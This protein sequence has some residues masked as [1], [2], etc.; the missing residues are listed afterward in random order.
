[1]LHP[2]P[3]RAT[4][5]RSHPPLPHPPRPL[6]RLGAGARAGS[7]STTVSWSRSST[8]SCSTSCA[9]P[10]SSATW[11]TVTNQAPQSH[12]YK[13]ISTLLTPVRSL[14][15]S[16]S[17]SLIVPYSAK[18]WSEWAFAHAG[19]ALWNNLPIVTNNNYC[20][21][22]DS[23]KSKIL[24]CLM[25]PFQGLIIILFFCICTVPYISLYLFHLCLKHSTE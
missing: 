17:G 5:R 18:S 13:V 21:S 25:L 22:P 20:I 23:F 2:T 14:R 4:L 6:T 8:R 19:H 1:M 16:N 9:S 24:T 10:A 11:S 3:W 7:V 12:R 15:S